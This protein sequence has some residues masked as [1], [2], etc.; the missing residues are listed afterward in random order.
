MMPGLTSRS[1]PR[2]CCCSQNLE[3]LALSTRVWPKV[4]T[5]PTLH[6][7]ELPGLHVELDRLMADSMRL[8][9][10]SRLYLSITGRLTRPHQSAARAL[11]GRLR[12]PRPA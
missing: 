7:E 11:C 4:V 5:I 8:S 10:E 2:L 1:S 12:H 3:T 6:L 9:K